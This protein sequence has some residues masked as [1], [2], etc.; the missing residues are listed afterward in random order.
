MST[1]P[2]SEPDSSLLHFS[3]NG[4]YFLGYKLCLKYLY[5]KYRS[6]W[7]YLF[8]EKEA[9]RRIYQRRTFKPL[10]RFGPSKIRFC[11]RSFD[12][13]MLG[14]F[15]KDEKRGSVSETC[16]HGYIDRLHD[17]IGGG[18]KEISARFRR[19]SALPQGKT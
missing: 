8:P 9:L 15:T 5:L 10:L 6:T 4:E 18:G 3:K 13:S 14:L 2:T 7:K 17:R 12:T 19:R 16:N 1:I 11:L